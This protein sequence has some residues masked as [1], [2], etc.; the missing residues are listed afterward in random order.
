MESNN[1]MFKRYREYHARKTSRK[2]NLEDIFRRISVCSDPLILKHAFK[3]KR[4]LRKKIPYS[5]E[6]SQNL[7]STGPYSLK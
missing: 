6:V 5:K 3:I 1:K 7:K 2:D 4:N